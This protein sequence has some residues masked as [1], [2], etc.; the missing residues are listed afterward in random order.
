MRLV[1]L[2]ARTTPEVA[3]TVAFISPDRLR[4]QQTGQDYFVARLAITDDLPDG[5]DPGQ[6][7]PGMP[8]EALIATEE[9]TFLQY[10][11]RPIVDSLHRA[12]REE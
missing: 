5:I 8:A 3:A 1:A 10:L 9:R 2:N 6:I 7:Y 4:D 12:F 11:S